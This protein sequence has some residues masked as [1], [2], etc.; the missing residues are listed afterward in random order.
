[1]AAAHPHRQRVRASAPRAAWSRCGADERGRTAWADGRS[2]RRLRLFLPG[3]AWQTLLAATGM[4]VRKVI[5]LAVRLPPAAWQTGCPST[6]NS[7]E[8]GDDFLGV[9][10]LAEDFE[11]VRG[12]AHLMS[13]WVSMV[14]Q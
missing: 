4:A 8:S 1:M 14:D 11:R 5:E 7:T 10:W 12:G 6:M 13:A 9:A 3:A 2:A